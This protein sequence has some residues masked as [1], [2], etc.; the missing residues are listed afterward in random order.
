M[1]NT[2]TYTARSAEQ[3]E[4]V[5]TFTLHEDKLSISLGA[6][7]EQI[8]LAVAG[9]TAED[10]AEAPE[11]QLWLKPLALSLIERGTGPFNITDVDAKIVGDQLTING[12]VRVGGLR[13]GAIT[14]MDGRVD[15][16]DA[17][18]AFVEELAA[19]KEELAAP[20]MPLDYW[21]TWFGIFAS[22]II[23][24]VF[25]RRRSAERG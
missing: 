23:L 15:N 7:L 19:R 1:D 6:P 8:E 5:V 21:M 25:W 3:P 22:L 18:L 20:V 14:L 12:W 17:A 2:Y 9:I 13:G 11:A 24:F 4:K 10:E 16:P